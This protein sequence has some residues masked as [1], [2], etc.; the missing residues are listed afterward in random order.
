MAEPGLAFPFAGDSPGG[1]RPA[2]EEKDRCRRRKAAQ[3]EEVRCGK[4]RQGGRPEE[5]RRR[6]GERE[7]GGERQRGEGGRRRVR[8][9][10][11]ERRE[12]GEKR[13]RY[14]RGGLTGGPHRH[15][16]STSPKPPSK[17]PRWPN[18]TGFES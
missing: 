4:G 14:E 9:E 11:E 12:R 8:G 7:K 5:A 13:E 3:E 6:L 16:A 2:G 10:G 1:G 17:P 18:M 15:V